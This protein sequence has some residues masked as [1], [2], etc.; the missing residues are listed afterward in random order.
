M[1]IAS[2]EEVD[3]FL[4]QCRVIGRKSFYLAHRPENKATLSELGFTHKDVLD[5]VFNLTTGD[6][7]KGPEPDRNYRGDCWFFGKVINGKEVYIKLE[8]SRYNNPGD[9]VD[10]LYCISFHFSN[11]KI[12]YP[13]KR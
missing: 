3:E 12:D 4:K 5:T 10:T 13:Y 9:K 11:N 6:Y 8:I 2:R 7:S 1:S